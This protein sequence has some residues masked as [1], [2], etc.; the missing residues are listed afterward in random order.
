M[1]T[2]HASRL[3]LKRGRTGSDWRS[4]VEPNQTVFGAIQVDLEYILISEANFIISI[5]Y[6]SG[7]YIFLAS[8]RELLDV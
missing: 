3:Q 8:P 7:Y 6:Y 5:R 1:Y 4:N 2:R